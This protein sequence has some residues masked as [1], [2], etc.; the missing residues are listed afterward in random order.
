M[1]NKPKFDM[2]QRAVSKVKEL[3][4][5]MRGGEYLKIGV[6]GGGC[7]GFSYKMNFTNSISLLEDHFFQFDGLKVAIDRKSMPL[8]DGTTLD[9]T[10]ELHGGGFKFNNPN[11]GPTCGCGESFAPKR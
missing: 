11:A 4:E 3:R 7:S 1:A 9:Y 5:K 2:T 10:D 8:L 6:V